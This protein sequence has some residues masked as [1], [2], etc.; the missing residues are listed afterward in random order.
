MYR[1]I[2]ICIY[3]YNYTRIDTKIHFKHLLARG[4]ADWGP[5]T[6][7]WGTTVAA[8][9]FSENWPSSVCPGA[10][11]AWRCCTAYP[12]MVSPHTD[13]KRW[14]EGKMCETQP[15]W[16]TARASQREPRLYENKK[17]SFSRTWNW[18]TRTVTPPRAPR[19]KNLFSTRMI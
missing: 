9:G 10:P 19:I 2:D 14:E 1:S 3:T 17:Y 16:V 13:N 12:P 8:A 15:T 5:A 11:L 18:V 4:P 7:P 6:H